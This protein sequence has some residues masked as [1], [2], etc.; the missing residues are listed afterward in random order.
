MN[1]SGTPMRYGRRVPEIQVAPYDSFRYTPRAHAT[2]HPND[3][4]IVQVIS[5][6][7]RYINYV[8]FIAVSKTKYACVLCIWLTH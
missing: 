3:F 1:K 8:I 2:S 7:Y 5:V 4:I 6:K